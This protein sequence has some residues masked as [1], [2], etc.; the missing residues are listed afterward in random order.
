MR[1]PRH[2]RLTAIG[3]VLFVLIGV[4]LGHAFE[5]I[6]VWGW[7]GI[8]R[9]LTGSS[10]AYM[11]PVG[12]LLAIASALMARRAWNS[13]QRLASRLDGASRAL[14]LALRGRRAEVATGGPD[15]SLP[16]W[17]S[18]I[19]SLATAL[20]VAQVVLYILQENLE[21]LATGRS[22]PGWGAITGVHWA[23]SLIQLDI[24][25][26]LVAFAALFMR[27]FRARVTYATAIEALVR[28]LVAS[29]RPRSDGPMRAIFRGSP[30][31]WLGSSIWSRPPPKTIATF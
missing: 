17:E 31:A 25:F 23:A 10:H 14:R 30:H 1:V 28:R 12:L 2:L 3:G 26:V 13:W 21:A 15:A 29:L 11:L 9:A 6:R 7:T 18:R 8:D 22:L 4:W 16:S 5:Y 27:R 19:L 20:A 24:A